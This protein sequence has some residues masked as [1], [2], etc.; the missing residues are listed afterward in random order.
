MDA[1]LIANNPQEEVLIKI[2]SLQMQNATSVQRENIKKLFDEWDREV[3]IENFAALHINDSK[4]AYNSHNDRHENL[5]EGYIGLEGFKN[6]AK[7]KRINHLPWILEVPG[8]DGLG[9]DKKNIELLK[10]IV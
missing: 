4:T 3:G 5:G 9:P 2:R 6:L 10:S 1:Q 7:E 8:F